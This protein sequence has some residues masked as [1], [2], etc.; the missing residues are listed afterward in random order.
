MATYR[1]DNGYGQRGSTVEGPYLADEEVKVE[2]Q[3]FF[4]ALADV[5]WSVDPDGV[6]YG[7]QPNGG[8]AYEAYLRRL[9]VPADEAKPADYEALGELWAI[10]ERDGSLEVCGFLERRELLLTDI[11]RASAEGYNTHDVTDVILAAPAGRGGDSGITDWVNFLGG[12]GLGLV[13][14]AVSMAL[15]GAL[16]RVGLV[17]RTKRE[18][19]AISRLAVTWE[20][21]GIGSPYRLRRWIDKREEWSAVE[22]ATRLSMSVQGTLR[23]LTAL[24]YEPLRDDPDTFVRSQSKRALKHRK[25]WEQLE[26]ETGLFDVW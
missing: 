8:R 23:L 1:P 13:T 20:A 10:R 6:H 19:V 2:W 22:V 9:E 3:T 21:R 18:D 12:L 17:V 11:L 15:T 5:L 26:T 16:S 7:F 4:T 25:R 14:N 24:G